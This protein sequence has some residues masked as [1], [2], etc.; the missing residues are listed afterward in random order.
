[1]IPSRL[2]RDAEKRTPSRPEKN[3]PMLCKAE[4]R[5]DSRLAKPNG[6]RGS[7]E[8]KTLKTST[9]D[10]VPVRHAALA[11]PRQLTSRRLACAKRLSVTSLLSSFGFQPID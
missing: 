11:L 4:H 8:R 5:P 10:P 2:A 3:H 1:L 6:E 9:Q 7:L